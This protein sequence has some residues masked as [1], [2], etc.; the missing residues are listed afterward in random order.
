MLSLNAK[1][2]LV[3]FRRSFRDGQADSLR[4][5]GHGKTKGIQGT[6][7]TDATQGAS[8][9]KSDWGA[10]KTKQGDLVQVALR[11]CLFFRSFF[12]SI[13]FVDDLAI[14]GRRLQRSMR[15]AKPYRPS[16]SPGETNTADSPLE[17]AASP[18]L[19]VAGALSAATF[20][21]E[22]NRKAFWISFREK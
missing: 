6:V 8:W 9:I 21:S 18:G 12:E 5:A 15:R 10:F 20:A 1:K 17:T 11:V 16:A 7:R 3:W 4:S 14:A 13:A 22:A 19:V 2:E